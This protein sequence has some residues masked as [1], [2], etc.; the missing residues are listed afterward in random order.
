MYRLK[1][2]SAPK[3]SEPALGSSIEVADGECSIGRVT[4][5]R[6]VLNSGNVSKR[7]AVLIVDNTN[8]LLKDNGSSNGT[9]VNGELTLRRQLNVGDKIS[10]GEYVFELKTPA[11][12]A[13]S[14]A[15]APRGANGKVLSFPNHKAAPSSSSSLDQFPIVLDLPNSLSS[16][17]PHSYS[18]APQSYSS[19]PHPSTGSL[20]GPVSLLD[21]AKHFLEHRVL[22][23]FYEMNTKHEWRILSIALVGL[24][25]VSTSLIGI[26]PLIT[27]HEEEFTKELQRKAKMIAIEIAERNSIYVMSRQDS[28]TDVGTFSRAIS[29][30]I[31]GV[32]ILDLDLKVISPAE[33]AGQLLGA[34]E[35]AQFINQ[36]RKGY[37]ERLDN[38]QLRGK[39]KKLENGSIVAVEPIR[40]YSSKIARNVIVGIA[41]VIIDGDIAMMSGGEMAMAYGYALIVAACVGMLIFYILYRVTLKPLREMN[42]KV[43]ASLRGEMVDFRSSSLFE[44]LIPLWNVIDSAL[45]RIPR[46]D[47]MGNQMASGAGGL[48][49]IDLMPSLK[50]LAEIATAPSALFDENRSIVYLNT[51]FE[52]I[53][54]I[55]NDSNVGQLIQFAARD[56]GLISLV[57]DLFGRVTPGGEALQESFEFSGV[58]YKVSCVAFGAMGAAK[59]FTLTLVKEDVFGS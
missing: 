9:F 14:G 31:K 50:S 27:A 1:V 37:V 58:A 33:R 20:P 46:E 51:L 10:I 32:Y 8:V 17:A 52:E 30:G 57:D 5:N 11:S 53:T 38:D 25:L 54:G 12:A 56:Q 2:I 29:N 42:D 16:P 35:E 6:I 59:G 24:F 22:P 47:E 7:H 19:V 34:G 45:K 48:Q 23:Y 4:G 26:W 43:D 15:R 55:R 28:K 13:E 40:A 18:S 49:S 44:E 21:K 41:A 36:A 3:N 39:T